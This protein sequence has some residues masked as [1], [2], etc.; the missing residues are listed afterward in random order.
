MSRAFP[1]LMLVFST[2]MASGT[3]VMVKKLTEYAST[4]ELFILRFLPASIISIILILIFYRKAA[5]KIVPKYWK[6]FLVRELI[7][8]LGF[9]LVFIY[10][11]S[12]L[13][14]GNVAIIIATWPVITIFLASIMIG[15]QLTFRKIFG[16]LLAFAGAAAVIVTMSNGDDSIREIPTRLWVCTSLILLIA[17]LSASIV[18]II[19]R[20]YLNTDD[21]SDP[22]LFTIIA[23]TPSGFIALIVYLIFNQSGSIVETLSNVPS[24]FWIL[25]AILAIYN[26]LFGFW[27]WNWCVQKL[28]AGTVSSF[29]YIQTGITLVIA[30][31]FLGESLGVEK[32]IGAVA[33]LAG[34]LIAN[35]GR[36]AARSVPLSPGS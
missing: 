7:A 30:W 8:V 12:I 13:P 20:R 1:W 18:T 19:T 17:P 25:I 36:Q 35:I 9:H 21:G 2:L 22:F 27:I 5:V 29:S 14:A 32:I 31:I 24:L 33:I 23:R 28:E 26:S 11:S 16:G 4:T 10:A 6:F 15:E 34:V 3:F